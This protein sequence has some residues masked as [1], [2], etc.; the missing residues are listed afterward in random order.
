MPPLVQLVAGDI[1]YQNC[2]H[3]I[4]KTN[5]LILT[6]IGTTGPW[7]LD[8]NTK[9]STLGSRGQRSRS[10]EAK[11]TCRFG[12]EGIILNTTGLLVSKSYAQ[13]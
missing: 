1:H 11:D 8:N 2:E 3:Y 4:L 5:K 7:A 12:G 13:A 9:Q 10:H 6:P